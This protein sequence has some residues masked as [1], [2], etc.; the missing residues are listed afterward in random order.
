MKKVLLTMVLLGCSFAA[1]FA[2]NFVMVEAESGTAGS[3]FTTVTQSGITFIRATT[4]VVASGNP[5]TPNRVVTYTVTFP[6]AG[7]YQLYAR[8]RVGSGGANDDSYFYANGFG[9]KQLAATGTAADNDWI[10]ANNLNNVG[11]T[12]SNIIVTG[13]GSVAA[14]NVWKWV[15]M[16]LFN[17]GESPISFNVPAG[18]LTQT[19]QIGGRENG[20]DLEKFVF[21]LSSFYFTVKNLDN[22]EPGTT[23]PPPPPYT[24]SGPPIATGKAKWLGSAYSNPQKVNFGKY[25]NQ[26]TPENGGK[27]GTVE[28]VRNVMNWS[29][30]DSAYKLAKDSGYP[31]K[32]HTLI[33]GSQQPAWI[34]SLPPDSQLIEIKEWYAAVAQRYPAIDFVEVVNEPLHQPPNRTGNGG[35]NYINALGGSG[36]SGWDWIITSFRLARQYF[37][38]STKLWLNDYSIINS[39]SAT[40]T[41][42]NIINL[43]KAENLIDG[44]G[45]QGHAFTTAGT[46]LTTLRNNVNALAATGLPVYITELDIDGPPAE[47]PQG[48]TVQ[49]REYQ[50]VFPLFWEHPAIKGITM[51]GHRPG[52]WRTAQG[53]PLVYANGAEKPAM[54]WLKQ[55]VQSTVLPVK[56]KLFEVIKSGSGAEITWSTTNEINNDRYEIERSTDGANYTILAIVK[57]SVHGQLSYKYST[58]DPSPHKGVNYYRLVQVDKDGKKTYY[59]VRQVNFGTKPGLFVQV[60]P[61][62]ASANFVVRTTPDALNQGSI[63]ILDVFGRSL[64]TQKLP[65]NGVETVSTLGLVSGTYFVRIDANGSRQVAKLEVRK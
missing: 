7:T 10:L 61:N 16:S 64:R 29:E 31:F 23:T 24:P 28:A 20:L 19:F 30:M 35:G 48:D 8:I 21:G 40:A 58:V 43:L 37:P 9:T 54:I 4:D 2:Q 38:A 34:E 65:S 41:Y 56:L 46:S 36:A 26:V 47:T 14:N 63:T 44:V 49:L 1:L 45:E 11:D 53:A 22:G 55:Y 50:R 12:T 13:S 27:W 42:V 3:E 59:G 32:M 52:H 51:W 33:W 6:M 25:W 60:Y 57:A 62:P 5:G 18:N 15:N 39:N 17:G